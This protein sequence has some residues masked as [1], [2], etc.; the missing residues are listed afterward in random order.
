M[1]VTEG[2]ESTYDCDGVS[3]RMIGTE[4]GESTYDSDGG[5]YL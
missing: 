5:V 4:G 1:M 2:G 3:L